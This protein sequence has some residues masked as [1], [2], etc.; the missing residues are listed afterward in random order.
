MSRVISSMEGQCGNCIRPAR[1]RD[2]GTSMSRP[3]LQ[4]E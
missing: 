2:S 3:E 1:N 4:V